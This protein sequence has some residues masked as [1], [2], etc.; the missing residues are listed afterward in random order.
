[1]ICITI[2]RGDSEV[3]YTTATALAR[4]TVAVVSKMAT[5]EHKFFAFMCSLKL[6]RQQQSSVRFAVVSTLNLR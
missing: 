5:V 6:S 4:R 1:M 2:K 3:S